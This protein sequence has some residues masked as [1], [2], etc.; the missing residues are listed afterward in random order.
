MSTEIVMH[1]AAQGWS[2]RSILPALRAGVIASLVIGV[3]GPTAA[4]AR[5]PDPASPV[6]P[7][8]DRFR[9]TV[10]QSALRERAISDLMRLAASPDPQIRA[11][12]IEG[13]APAK[14]RLPGPL[15]AALKD[16][17]EGVRAVAAVVAGRERVTEA[18]PFVRGLVADPSAF[19]RAS[20]IY[21]MRALGEPI[22][23]T[24]LGGLLLEYPD[25]GV[26]AH[27]AFLL[28]ELGDK[29]ALP[30]LRQ[31]LHM[32]TPSAS[33]QEARLLTLQIAEAMVKLGDSS[34]L[35]GIRAALYPAQPDEFEIAALA[36][37]ILGRLGD[38][39]SIGSLINLAEYR[40]GDRG[41][42]PEMRLSVA[43][44]VGRMGRREGWF[45]AE[46]YLRDEDPLRRSQAAH[47]LGQTRRPKDLATL[48]GLLDDPSPLVQSAAASAVLEATRPVSGR[49]ARAPLVP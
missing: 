6:E 35:E 17:N 5:Q 21:A 45:I 20:A 40:Q 19:V 33:P 28:G 4:A 25:S 27:A 46:E 2:P 36:V 38:R 12:S 9:S 8:E 39:S 22:D 30:M 10:A 11:N 26:R 48:E 34:R 31:A 7:V 49:E 43:E 1:T 15:A 14:A 24:P 3:A 23:P 41:M 47:V 18:T 29:S 13:L 16:E 37:Q 32:E 42:P 44:A